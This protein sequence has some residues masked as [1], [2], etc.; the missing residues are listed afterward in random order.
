MKALCELAKDPVSRIAIVE[1]GGI[2]RLATLLESTHVVVQ[3]PRHDG[4]SGLLALD[5]ETH[6]AICR[7][8]AVARLVAL[9]QRQTPTL[10]LEA[11]TTLERLVESTEKT[12]Q[13]LT[14]IP[15]VIG[16]RGIPVDTNTTEMLDALTKARRNDDEECVSRGAVDAAL[17]DAHG[18]N[19]AAG[20]RDV[21]ADGASDLAHGRRRD[22]G[23]CGAGGR[24]RCKRSR[25]T[26]AG[27]SASCSTTASVYSCRSWTK[28]T[29]SSGTL[30]PSRSTRSPSTTPRAARSSCA[31]ASP[32]LV[33]LAAGGTTT[34]RQYAGRDLG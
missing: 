34:Q 28:A 31:T 14:I 15:L 19:A 23:A 8:N 3:Q 2:Q 30:R 26:S 7:T 25:K 10:L 1:A 5:V 22:D 16:K 13:Q 27:S 6:D 21:S 29:K 33:R 4:R 17:E 24:R 18:T 32:P 12:H 20:D 9:A 11:L